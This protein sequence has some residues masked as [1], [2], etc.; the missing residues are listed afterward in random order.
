[1]GSVTLRRGQVTGGVAVQI[2]L[3][4]LRPRL[5]VVAV[6]LILGMLLPAES[7]A[8]QYAFV[9]TLQFVIFAVAAPA[10]LVLG[11][12][13]RFLRL[14]RGQGS[15]PGLVR[16]FTR[17]PL[18]RRVPAGSGAGGIHRRRDRLAIAGDG[19]RAAR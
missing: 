11:G 8:R 12:P 14:T 2:W 4:R 17:I 18:A 1:M 15:S 3:V 16:R 6:V 10:L 13:W 9:E 7:Y 19:Q 5:A